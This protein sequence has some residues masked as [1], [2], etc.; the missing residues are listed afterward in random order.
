MDLIRRIREKTALTCG[1]GLVVLDDCDL[2]DRMVEDFIKSLVIELEQTIESKS[3]GTILVI[4]T[5]SGAKT[6]KAQLATADLTS[7]PQE[8][9]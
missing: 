3:S 2:E 8:L 5:S 4:T 7:L 6:V 1:Y 9:H